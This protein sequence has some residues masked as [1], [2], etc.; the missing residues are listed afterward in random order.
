MGYAY[1]ED[2][3]LIKVIS[4]YYTKDSRIEILNQKIELKLIKKHTEGKLHHLYFET[5]ER[6]DTHIDYQILLDSELINIH[7]GK[8]TRSSLFDELN[9]YDGELGFHYT[10][11]GTT[12][13]LWT[14]VSKEV[15]VVLPKL[16]Q[17]YDLKYCGKGLYET[18][19]NKN[20]NKQPYYYLVR[21]NDDFVRTMDPY[22][23]SS[24][25]EEKVNFVIDKN[26]TYK[27]KHLR[28]KFSGNLTDAIIMEAHLKDLTHDLKGSSNYLKAKEQANYF[29][30]LGIT[31]VQFLPVNSFYGVD[32]VN[33]DSLYNWGYN[34]LEYMTLTGWY[35]SYPNDPY[36]KINEFKELIDTYHANNL[37][38]NLDV[39]FNHVYKHNMFSMGLLVPGYAYRCDEY[40]FLTNGSYCGNDLATERK[41]IRKLIVDTIIHYISFYKIDGFRFDLMGLID[42]ETMKTIEKHAK[43]LNS[44]VVLYGEGWVMNTGLDNALL[45]SNKEALPNVGYFNDEYRDYLRGNPFK[46]DKGIL[47]GSKI[48]KDR[49]TYLLKGSYNPSQS[50]NYIEC[51]DNYTLNDQM[52]L[53]KKLSENE[54][55][56]YLKLGLGLLMISEGIP[57]IH[58]GMEIGRTKKGID[59]SYKD[60]IEINKVDFSKANTYQDVLIYLKKMI[61]FRK[62]NT[63]FR[64][65]NQDIIND[66]YKFED[67]N[68]LYFK[69]LVSDFEII[70]TNTY[71]SFEY[72][73]T[74]IDKPGVY[75]FK[76]NKLYL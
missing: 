35:A 60:S 4:E 47:V 16:N 29:K 27:M 6:L 45:A 43:K 74:L 63:A 67:A 33:K 2:Y 22:G 40:G 14:P 44:S 53:V 55:K 5:S 58:L 30:E 73:Q 42:I 59:N 38:V 62:E 25:L 41:M 56:D 24:S 17:I 51:H 23:I 26:M 72:H 49:L 8:I 19:V 9:Y 54:K 7:L 15:K 61:E 68:G 48:N 39:V 46:L 20:L 12:F 57:F 13:R 3:Q 52:D 65:N 66:V 71:D 64:L 50:I 21:I 69:Y 11:K 76:D 1:L 18:T 31:H 28:P 34:P 10:K 70:I 36:N 32:E 75:I 37:L